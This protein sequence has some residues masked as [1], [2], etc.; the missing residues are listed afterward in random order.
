MPIDIL[1]LVQDNCAFCEHAHEI[2]D[3]LQQEYPLVVRTVDID[4]EQGR[5][6]AEG[7]GVMFAPGIFIDGEA[8]SY[9]RL[10]ER[11]LR[12]RLASSLPRL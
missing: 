11:K 10:S 4:T 7:G 8:F 1:M 2:L 5:G 6:L 3:R 9:G 12:K